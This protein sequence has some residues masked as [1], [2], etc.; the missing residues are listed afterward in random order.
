MHSGGVSLRGRDATF[1]TLPTPR[2]VPGV[3]S[4][5]HLPKKEP[6]VS[7]QT[8]RQEV[9][10]L[11]GPVSPALFSLDV[12]SFPLKKRRSAR[13]ACENKRTLS[14]VHEEATRGCLICVF[15]SAAVKVKHVC[16]QSFRNANKLPFTL[17][18]CISAALK[19]S[20]YTVTQPY[21]FA[22]ESRWKIFRGKLEVFKELF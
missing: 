13:S 15:C 9:Q 8:G 22:F 16:V 21:N 11:Y 17:T 20:V 12:D 4:A 5:R 10:N 2:K 1:K 3:T 19:V 18:F 14:L 6:P 7:P